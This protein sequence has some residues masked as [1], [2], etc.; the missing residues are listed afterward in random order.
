MYAP[1]APHPLSLLYEGSVNFCLVPN[2]ELGH[3]EGLRLNR[4]ERSG[5]V[6]ALKLPHKLNSKHAPPTSG[7]INHI[8]PEKI[9]LQ[10]P[11]PPP[12]AVSG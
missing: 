7:G 9:Q 12:V 4:A 3:P 10:K 8:N 5:I 2:P 1:P 11:V 6:L